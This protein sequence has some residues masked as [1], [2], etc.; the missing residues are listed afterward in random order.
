MKNIRII[1]RLDIKGPNLVKGIHLEGLR[2]LGKPE[3]FAMEYYKCGADELIYQDTVASLYERNSLNSIISKTVNDIF[4]PITV[5]GGI[6]TLDDINQVLRSGADKVSINTAA[7][8]NPDFI[9]C[10]S[11]AFGSSTIV[12]AV[13]A[14]KQS[15]NLYLAYTDNGRE[16]TGKDVKEWVREAQDR[17]VGEILLTSIDQE[18]TGRGFDLDLIKMISEQITV[19]LI[20]HGGCSSIKHIIDSVNSGA[21]AICIASKLHYNAIARIDNSENKFKEEGN[22]DFLKSNKINKQFNGSDNLAEIKKA[23]SSKNIFIRT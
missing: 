7:I 8:K 18:G 23:L 20:A 17:G 5:G 9:N 1:P 13:E 12:L 15:E 16:Q 14:I 10:A 22:T 2:V 21:D 6:R 19:P 11:K 4:I 3:D